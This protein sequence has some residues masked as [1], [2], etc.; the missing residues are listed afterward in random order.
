MRIPAEI[1][2]LEGYYLTFP[3]LLIRQPESTPRAALEVV[4]GPERRIA[5]GLFTH[6]RIR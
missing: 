2:F 3:G 4:Q 6:L 1:G 5:S